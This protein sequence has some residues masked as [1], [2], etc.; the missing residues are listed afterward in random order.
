MTARGPR[1]I[2]LPS[3]TGIATGE[4]PTSRTGE[5][6]YLHAELARFREELG[7]RD[8]TISRLRQAAAHLEARCTELQHLSEERDR[9]VAELARSR[10]ELERLRSEV[11]ALYEST[12][13]RVTAPMRGF[14]NA[15]LR[16]RSKLRRTTLH[17]LPPPLSPPPPPAA[18]AV[19]DEVMLVSRSGLFDPGYYAAQAP[20]LAETGLDPVVHYLARGTTEGLDPHPLFDTSF[21]R[22]QNPDVA[23][24]RE[25]AL[26]HYLRVGAGEDRDPHPLFDTSFYRGQNPD[27]ATS[28]EN[29]LVHYLR[30]GTAEDRDPHP[31]FDAS[32]YRERNPGVVQVGENP[33]VHYLRTG[34]AEGLDPHP[35]FDSSHYRRGNPG[36]LEPRGNPLLHYLAHGGRDVPDP[37]PLFETS[38]YLEQHPD[39]GTLGLNPLVHFATEGPTPAFDPLSRPRPLPDAGICIVTPDVV[40]P[41]KNGGIGTACYH[42][43][44]ILAQSDRPVSVLFTC[45]L[46]PCRQAHWRNTYARMG[47]KFVPLEDTPP[48]THEVLAS[49]WFMERSWRVFKYLE[50]KSYS[51]IH[52]QDWHANGFWSI[53]AKQV[54]LAFEQTTLTVMTHSPTKWQDDGMQQFGPEPIETA[55][56]VWAEAYAIEHCDALL[57]PTRYMLDWL[58]QNGFRTPRSVIVTPNSYTENTDKERPSGDVDNDHLIFFG[59]LETRKGLHVLGEALRL[60]RREGGPVPHTVSFLGTLV[61]VNGRPAAEYLDELRR[62]LAPT[63]FR[64]IN[65]LDH[66]SAREY[67]ERT[68]GLVVIPS[69]VDNCPFVV[70]ESIENGFPFLAARTGGIPDMVDARATFEPTPGA[71]AARLAERHGIDHAGLRHPY[72]VRDATR[73]WR[74]L[75]GDQG[76]FGGR[77]PDSR[78]S[79]GEL[80][81]SPRVSVCIPFFEHHRYLAGLV[82]AF[83]DQ[84]YPDLEVVVVN[85]GSGPEAS[86]EFDRIAADTRDGRFRFLITENRGP[87]AA[88]NAAAEAA[89]GDLFLFFDADNVPKSRDFVATLAR[90]LRWSGADCVTCAYDIVRANPLAPAEQD[91]ISTYRPFGPCLEAGFFQN[92]L[93]GATMILPRSVFTE[94]GGFPT[95][96]ASWEAHEFLLRVCFQ[97]FRL[98]T[99]P[100]ALFYYRESPSDG[101]QRANHFLRFRSLFEQLRAAPSEDLAHILAVVGGPMLVERL[102]AGSARIVGR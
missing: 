84:S 70:I 33:L 14:K 81:E 36:G 88:R 16:L 71:L 98:E 28:G 85:D 9:H 83:A 31:L 4:H 102:G 53:K 11:R 72:S 66:A 49:N 55:K 67:I 73:I 45:D 56:L 77:S 15:V 42:F 74:D 82:A 12:S 90:A 29:P 54:G 25:N 76:P 46:S 40:G 30:A 57:S 64:I 99:F 24:A 100:E 6:E 48:V 62:E 17:P 91:V 51:V 1:S 96:R 10:D 37:H 39:V 79:A 8:V 27:V 92:V 3:A 21:Y 80:D 63:E 94:V 50:R 47:I 13:W 61:T 69:L 65:N 44:R 26:V 93:G 22:E 87:G 86:R 35:L 52:F 7:T 101:N 58:S 38:F 43:A 75:H 97:G 19:D 59:R 20:D 95:G 2:A 23:A 18:L 60:L 34:A 5:I 68:R 78:R 41:V 32:F 89:T